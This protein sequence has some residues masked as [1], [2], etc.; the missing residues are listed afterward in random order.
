MNEI[1]TYDLNKNAVDYDKI[2]KDS[3]VILY[4]A[5]ESYDINFIVPVRGRLSFSKPMYNSFVDANENSPLKIAY[6]VVEHSEL[7]EHSKFCKQN[8]INYI[9]IKSEAG[10]QFNKCLALN[11]GA[12]FSMVHAKAYLFHDIDCLIQSDFFIKLQENIQN[13]NCKAIQC[14]HG[15][16]VLYLDQDRTNKIIANEISVNDLRL[17]SPGVS[18]PM[19]IGA[20]GGSIYIERYLFFRVGGYD[21]EFFRANAPEDI[22][23]WDKVCIIDKME[24]SDNPE[25][26]LFHMNH[27]PTYYDNPYIG[28][29]KQVHDQFKNSSLEEKIELV[30]KK[31]DLIKKYYDSH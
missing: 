18:L 8:K 14:F 29:M 24:V 6:T 25:I 23:F 21:P 1:F 3:V 5:D 4:G 19:Y 28:H 26:D 7:P 10:E 11:M 22:F 2:H 17:G 31:A 13:K 9:W 15:R 30:N 16:R 20:P 12:L 27:P